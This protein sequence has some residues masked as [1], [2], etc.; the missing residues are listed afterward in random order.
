MLTKRFRI[1]FAAAVLLATPALADS[2]TVF[3]AASLGTAL[4]EVADAFKNDTGHDTVLSFAGSSTLARQI[5]QG[6]PAD[7]FISA[8]LAWMDRLQNR[9][10]LAPDTRTDILSN[11]LALISHDP[12][13]ETNVSD[14]LAHLPADGHLAM[15]QVNAVP[16]GIYGKA[17]LDHLGL[18]ADVSS[19]VV[20]ADNVR[21]ALALV[22]LGEAE[23]GIVY[24]TDAKAEPRVTLV[25]EFTPDTHLPITYPAA[26]IE[27]RTTDAALEF[28]N[29]LKS[30]TAIAIFIA[31]GF[32]RATE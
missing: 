9:G 27:S 30:D 11:Q 10:R 8:N 7:V 25:A 1:I 4:K 16:A 5:E 17:A 32:A 24:T 15:G 14:A 6:A 22:A 19:R 20:Q 2:V 28:L 21:A 31:Q 18:W 26:I 23:M 29:Y 12:T 13:A 3:A